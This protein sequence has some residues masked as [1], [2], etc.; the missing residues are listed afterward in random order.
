MSTASRGVILIVETETPGSTDRALNF[1]ESRL[2]R[3]DDRDAGGRSAQPNNRVRDPLTV[4][5]HDVLAM[6]S[7]GFSNKLLQQA[8]PSDPRDLAGDREIARQTHLLKA[9]RQHAHRSRISS[10]IAWPIAIF[11]SLPRRKRI[12]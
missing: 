2:S 11:G 7:Q 10:W 3:W 4:R 9:G 8:Y 6:I 1:E 5:E 12:A